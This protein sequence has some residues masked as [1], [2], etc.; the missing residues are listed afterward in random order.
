MIIFG[1][2]GFLARSLVIA[3]PDW[4][5]ITF[6]RA[7]WAGDVPHYRHIVGDVLDPPAVRDAVEG[8]EL[9]FCRHGVLGGPH[10]VAVNQCRRYLAINAESVMSILAACDRAGCRRVILDSS[11]Q[12]FGQSGDL[13]LL[14]AYAEPSPMNFYGATKL[15]A[16]KALQMWTIGEPDR[17]AQVFRY[18]RV[19]APETR[20]VVYHFVRACL[21]NKP[22]QIRSN[23]NHKLSFVHVNDVIAANRVALTRKPRVAAY[24]VSCERPIALYDLAQRIKAIARSTSPIEIEFDMPVGLNFEPFITGMEW[25]SSAEELGIMP[26]YGIDAMILQTIAALR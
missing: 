19:R 22:V 2:A 14:S 8:A 12:V 3:S 16:E 18:S 10:S 1:G 6:D 26:R 25:E 24:N 17:S 21:D 4:E 7:A 23:P 15:V 5:I 9:A 20:D 13:S 11:E